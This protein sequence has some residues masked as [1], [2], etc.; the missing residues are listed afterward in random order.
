MA[1]KI[2]MLRDHGQSQKYYHEVEGYNGRLDAIQ[3]G[4][5][6]IKLRHVREWNDQRRECAARYQ[7]LF[8]SASEGIILPYE[9]SWSR[10]VYHLY[11]IRVQ[12][13]IQLQKHLSEANIGTGIHYPVPLH[14]QNAY[15]DLD[16][17]EGSFPVT[18]K[19]VKEILS[20]PMYPG[21][22]CDQQ[23]RIVNQVTELV[24]PV[25]VTGYRR[26]A[27]A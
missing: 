1:G 12:D 10:A 5:L 18:E 13:R 9:P 20:L 19:V 7:E 16:C 22:G 23:N 25:I 15:A 24:S 17:G 27:V 3:A 4:I 2:R 26:S 14:L 6:Q 11:V 8:G 21:L